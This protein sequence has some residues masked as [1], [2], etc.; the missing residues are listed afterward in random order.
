MSESFD[1]PF[2]GIPAFCKFPYVKNL[3]GMD[4][5]V[6]VVGAPIDQ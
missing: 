1:L 2:A 3:E 5:D 4:V 6:A